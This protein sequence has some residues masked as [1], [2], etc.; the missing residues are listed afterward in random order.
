MTIPWLWCKNFLS[1]LFWIQGNVITP[2]IGY[3]IDNPVLILEG[4]KIVVRPQL[5]QP[6]RKKV[7][8]RNNSLCGPLEIGRKTA[9]QKI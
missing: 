1:F 3:L 6:K 9:K 2:K 5:T 4:N 8:R 7:L